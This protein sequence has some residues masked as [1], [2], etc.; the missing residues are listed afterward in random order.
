MLLAKVGL[1]HIKPA[2]PSRYLL[3]LNLFNQADLQ[4]DFGQILRQV[5]FANGRP[6]ARHVE[7][8][9]FVIR[10]INNGLP[11]NSAAWKYA[12]KER[13]HLTQA[14]IFSEVNKTTNGCP[15]ADCRGTL[16]LN[17][18]GWWVTLVLIERLSSNI[19]YAC[20]HAHDMVARCADGH[21]LSKNGHLF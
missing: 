10:A 12:V 19:P 7:R 6:G 9:R 16:Q 17:G 4:W 18:N 20:C 5:V 21:R 8:G 14:M 13:A 15:F 3:P 2:R 1:C 11:L